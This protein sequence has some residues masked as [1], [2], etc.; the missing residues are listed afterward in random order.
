M[1]CSRRL[2][3]APAQVENLCHQS[4]TLYR[5]SK[6]KAAQAEVCGYRLY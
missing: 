5:V 2:Q 6:N 4:P 3:P 1:V